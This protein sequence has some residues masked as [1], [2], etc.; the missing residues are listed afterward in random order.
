MATEVGGA[1]VNGTAEE[2]FNR[3]VWWCIAPMGYSISMTLNAWFFVRQ[4]SEAKCV[5]CI[6]ALQKAYGSALGGLV[7]LP[8]CLGDCE[9]SV[10]SSQEEDNSV[11]HIIRNIIVITV[12][13]LVIIISLLLAAVF[14]WR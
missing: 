2:V 13:S 4:L 9:K 11:Q 1:F 14:I 7:Y 5:T 6:D 8:S 10:T 3:G 12:S